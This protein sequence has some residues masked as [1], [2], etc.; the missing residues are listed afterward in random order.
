MNT[1]VRYY[2]RSGN[3]KKIAEAIAKGAGCSA[4]SV[5]AAEAAITEDVDVLYVGGALYAYGIDKKLKAYLET[6]PA[7]KV[8]KAVVFSTAMMSKHALDLIAKALKAKGIAVASETF[9]C[10]GKA[11]DQFIEKAQEFGKKTAE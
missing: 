5:D 9:Y 6:I 11:A 4:V 3:T 8:K 2:S 1:A 7:D 10:K